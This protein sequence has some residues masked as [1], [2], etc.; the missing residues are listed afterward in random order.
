MSDTAPLPPASGDE[1]YLTIEPAYIFTRDGVRPDGYAG[2]RISKLKRR[3][4]NAA[5]RGQFAMWRSVLTG[6][7][8]PKAQ[9]DLLAPAEQGVVPVLRFEALDMV[10][11]P[12]SVPDEIWRSRDSFKPQTD[13]EELPL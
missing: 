10:E 5:L 9:A 8:K 12:V 1:W 7:G 11:L 13:D 2:E 6:F 3:E 4:N